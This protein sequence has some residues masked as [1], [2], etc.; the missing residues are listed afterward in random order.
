MERMF[1]LDEARELMPELRRRADAAVT[2]RADLAE[3]AAALRA[4]SDSP[5]G[6]M[7][8][9]KAAEARFHEQVTWLQEQGLHVKG[10]APLLVDFPALLDGVE[11]LLCWLEGEPDLAWYHRPEVGF[12]G[13]RPL[14][15]TV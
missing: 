13:R 3:I 11:V 10:V 2:A 14:P 8:E 9:L 12:A 5:L 6:G 1:S 15:G 7:P 4:G